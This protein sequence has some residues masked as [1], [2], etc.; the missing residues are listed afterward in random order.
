MKK[1]DRIKEVNG[2]LMIRVWECNNFDRV[3][4]DIP[5]YITKKIKNNNLHNS[6]NVRILILRDILKSD[7]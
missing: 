7:E 3:A 6:A 4:N 1:I 5:I 2:D